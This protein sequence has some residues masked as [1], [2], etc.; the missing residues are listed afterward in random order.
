MNFKKYMSLAAVALPLTAAAQTIHFENDD[1][2]AIGVYDTWEK[3]PFRA[4]NG[5]AAQLEGNVAVIDNFLNTEDE[6]LGYAPNTTEKILGVQ[7]SRFGSNTFG[8]RIDLK[9]PF[10]LTDTTRYVHVFINKPKEGRVMLVGLGKRTERADQSPEAEQFWVLSTSVVGADSHWYDAVFPIRG[11]MP[12]KDDNGNITATI[13]IHSL[14]VVPDCESPHELT[15][16]FLAYVDEI[17]ISDDPNPRFRRGDY[18]VNFDEDATTTRTDRKLSSISL[19][20]SSDG[21]QTIDVSVAD[22]QTLY[23]PMLT[24]MFTAKAGETVTPLFGY[25]AKWMNGYV[26]L[27]RGHD[28]RFTAD[29]EEGWRIPEGSDLMTY[30]YVQKEEGGGGYAS[31]GS[32]VS[33]NEAGDRINPPAF[34][35]PADLANGFYRMRY[36]LDW[37]SVDPG[38]RVDESNHIAHNA[39]TIV[40]VLLNLHG[41]KVL[42]SDANRNGAVLSADGEDLNRYETPFG[43]P[44]TIKMDPENGFTYDGI[45]VTYGYNL[46]GDEYVHSTPQ[47]FTTEYPAYLFDEDDTFTL[48]AEIMIG[49]VRIEGLFV[50]IKGDTPEPGDDYPSNYGDDDVITR[51]D[52]SLN[53]ITFTATQG[54]ATSLVTSDNKHV[55]QNRTN[56]Q[57]KVMPGDEVTIGVN[58]TGRAMHH[59]L[60]VDY[61]QDGQFDTTL[62]E[63]GTPS[64][65]SE[66]VSYTY[67]E[68]KNSQGQTISGA[69]GDVAVNAAPSF[70]I[71]EALRPGKYRARFKTDW[72]N[73]DPAGQPGPENSLTDNGGYIIDFLLNVVSGNETVEVLTEHGSVNGANYTGLPLTAPVGTSLTVVPTPACDDFEF[74]GMTIKH[75]LNFD[76]PQY[77]H[78]N[79]Q[80]NEYTVD[81]DARYTIPAD[82]LDGNIVITA[83]WEPTSESEWRSV[84]VEEFDGEDGSQPDEMYWSRCVRENATWNR[85]LSD[86]KEVIYVQDGKLV[87]RA[88]PN[89][90]QTTDNVPMITG[91]IKTQGKFPFL[92]GKVEGRILTNPHKGNFPAFWMMPNVA[93]E[94]WPND[95]EIDIFEQIDTEN[96]A[97]HTVHSNWTYNLGNRNNP[98]SSF[99]ENVSMDRYHTYGLEWTPTLLTWYVDGKKVGSYAKSENDQDALS[100]GQWPFDHD[101]YIILNQSVGNGSWAANADVNHT[102]ETLF[103]WVRVY[104]KDN[105]TDGIGNVSA[106]QLLDVTATEGVLHIYTGSAQ[107][108]MVCDMAGHPIFD[109]IIEGY[110][111]INVMKG[112][113]LVNG[114][115]IL[116]P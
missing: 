24:K 71:H 85:W 4:Q 11:A 56:K 65:A 81:S 114:K 105:Y 12:I 102:Y 40:D 99:N 46:D 101:F 115:K 75:G 93:V 107:K 8:V 38:G 61:D 58:Y 51:T 2:K 66:L 97:Y 88:I 92:Y 19:N 32:E 63:D 95:G 44:F 37:G 45:R 13:E 94:G 50:E 27:D 96:K 86:S 52:R 72:N 23:R 39:G 67:Y 43:Q 76:G 21:N 47:Y 36:K 41:D 64:P 103:D 87:A 54:G 91:G 62:N 17:E 68:G 110:K 3:S 57:V 116:V 10:S 80:W 82:S 77:I 98:K 100:K 33:N 42:V 29:L 22:P 90:D 84:F 109:N 5:K 25:T 55:Y 73:L 20:G 34:T 30:A 15:S 78:G 16:D 59:Y 14:V 48:P 31:D 7:R 106:D 113:Y 104:Q 1:Y 89:P 70:K 108:V 83:L 69:A 18:V 53:S 6:L 9:E 49:E 79:R 28:G 60:Y 35:I 112:V 26:Y 111:D 74:K